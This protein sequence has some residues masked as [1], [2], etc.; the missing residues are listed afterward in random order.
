[1]ID[2]VPG[3]D[4]AAPTPMM[5]RPTSSHTAVGAI[6]ATTEPALNSASPASITFRR[7]KRSPNMPP[8]SI[9]L[10]KVRAYPLTTHCNVCTP[11]WSLP[12]MSASVTLTMVLSR[13]VT[14]STA[15]STARDA[16]RVWRREGTA[17]HFPAGLQLLEVGRTRLR[18]RRECPVRSVPAGNLT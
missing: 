9:R 4:P 7:P 17:G 11:A 15:Q 3:S 8:T 1:M 10:A 14:H 6:A 2:S 13:K 12:W 5:T 18:S 16:E